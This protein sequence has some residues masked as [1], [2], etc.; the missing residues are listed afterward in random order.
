MQTKVLLNFLLEYITPER[1][2]KFDKVL[3]NRTRH[4]T[5][6]L[7][8]IFQPHNA[9]AVLRSCDLTGI[10]DVH[11][12]ENQYEYDINPDVVVGSTKWLNLYKYNST[13]FNTPDAYESLR[14]KGY[15][16]VAT[17]PHE[18]GY[19]PENLP[20]DQPVALVFGTE[21]TGLSEEALAQADAFV[22]IPM[23]GF[24]E[25][26]NISVSAALLLYTLTNRLRL[27]DFSWPLTETERDEL[28]LQWCRNTIKRVGVLE[29]TFWKR[30]A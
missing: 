3:N 1:K 19:T 20:L 15:R 25:S 30:L 16:I 4:I 11:I 28:M 6:V 14:K 10:Q 7:E 22:R 5:I 2:A 8:D 27:T 18:S 13:K 29:E 21:K 23:V 24:T 17:S 12:I 9:S 26:Y